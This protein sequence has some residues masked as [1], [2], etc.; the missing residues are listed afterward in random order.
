MRPLGQ[1]QLTSHEG[2]S[3]CKW[4]FF[5]LTIN[6]KCGKLQMHLQPILRYNIIYILLCESIDVFR[7]GIKYKKQT[8]YHRLSFIGFWKWGLMG[9]DNWHRIR[10][11]LGVNEDWWISWTGQN[12]VNFKCIY[13]QFYV[14]I[15]FIFC[16][17]SQLM[18]FEAE[19]NIK[20]K[21]YTI[22]CLP[23]IFENQTSRVVW[24]KFL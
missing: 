16:C 21:L 3:K 18:Y 22:V 8:L 9:S 23:L 20:N 6:V 10:A 24:I 1:W 12:L 7:G 19:S 4:T 11:N 15:S 13:N 14:I 2:K 5:N 17:V